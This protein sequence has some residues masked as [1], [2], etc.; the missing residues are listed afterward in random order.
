[1]KEAKGSIPGRPSRLGSRWRL[2][3]SFQA[4]RQRA[5]KVRAT[6]WA[7]SQLGLGSLSIF[8]PD[9]KAVIATALIGPCSTGGQEILGRQC[10]SDVLDWDACTC[11]KAGAR[12]AW[13]VSTG[14][15]N[16]KDFDLKTV[17]ANRINSNVYGK[18][19][20][21]HSST[22]PLS[23]RDLKPLWD[24][25]F[26]S[27]FHLT[28]RLPYSKSL[29]SFVSFQPGSVPADYDLESTKRLIAR[30]AIDAQQYIVVHIV[31]LMFHGALPDPS[32]ERDGIIEII[33]PTSMTVCHPPPQPAFQ[34]PMLVPSR[35]SWRHQ[36]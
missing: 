19:Q 16:F 31:F 33:T 5:G 20:V 21:S 7:R 28:H 18:A 4:G 12:A 35:F 14:S 6:A 11:K 8:A 26:Q 2:A 29:K 30:R 23:C 27:T 15:R 22:I 24:S 25:R 10:I 1:M 36:V 9:Q 32:I 17:L 3:Y 13:T 34:F